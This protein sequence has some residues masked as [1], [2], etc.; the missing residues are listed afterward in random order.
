VTETVGAYKTEP[1]FVPQLL[2]D[3]LESDKAAVTEAAL[4]FVV[5]C[6]DE[7]RREPVRIALVKVF[8][9][10]DEPLKFQACLPLMR[11]FRDGEAWVYVLAQT[12][13]KDANRARTALNWIGDTK[14]CGQP[15][16]ARLLAGLDPLLSAATSDERRV[17][18]QVLSTFAGEEV[19]R[20]LIELLAD[21]DQS[22]AKQADASLMAQP[23]RKLVERLLKEAASKSPAALVRS[24][25]KDLLAKLSP[26]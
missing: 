3:A 25:A 12:Q 16:D 10:R 22:V 5:D 6:Q 9:K 26:S 11:D 24:R 8:A 21:A 4:R 13:S 14:N 23:D 1:R 17:G 19:A 7:R 18:I 15:P 20:R 2:V